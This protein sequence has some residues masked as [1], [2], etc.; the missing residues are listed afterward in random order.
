MPPITVGEERI[1]A[2]KIIHPIHCFY[3]AFSPYSVH[4]VML[5]FITPR[6]ILGRN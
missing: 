2:L 1:A 5:F 4:M 3:L 6:N